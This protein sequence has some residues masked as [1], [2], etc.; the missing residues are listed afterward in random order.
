MSGGMLRWNACSSR[1][2][3]LGTGS[4]ERSIPGE[5]M[6]LERSI[7]ALMGNGSA[8]G[9]EGRERF[10]EREGALVTEKPRPLGGRISSREVEDAV[11]LEE[12]ER[13][14][15]AT[16]MLRTG[17]LVIFLCENMVDTR[18]IRREERALSIVVKIAV[19]VGELC[20]GI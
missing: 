3:G 19:R 12:G 5:L 6:H 18:L 11:R 16:G 14:R 4:L 17:W 15:E 1:L 7:A 10:E 20:T 2:T 13:R 9:G 8:E